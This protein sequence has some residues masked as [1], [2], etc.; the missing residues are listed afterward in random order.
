MTPRYELLKTNDE[1]QPWL[2][3]DTAINS[4]VSQ[5][6]YQHQALELIDQLHK[7]IKQVTQ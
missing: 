3:F 6:P 7:I 2:V 5:H 4:K 1:K